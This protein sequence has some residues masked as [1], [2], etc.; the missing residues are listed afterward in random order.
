MP[1][2][3][4]FY[5]NEIQGAT[6]FIDVAGGKDKLVYAVFTTPENAVSGSAICSFKLSDIKHAFDEGQ[7][8][9]QATGNSNWLPV[10]VDET[11]GNRPGQCNQDSTKLPESTLN[12]IKQHSLMDEAVP[13]S[14]IRSSSTEV[15]FDGG[16]P[17]FV[18]TAFNQRLTVVAVDPQIKTPSGESYDVIYAGTTDG[19]VLKIVSVFKEKQ[20][21]DKVVISHKPV[22]LEEIQAFPTHFPIRNVHV[23]QRSASTMDEPRLVVLSD[24]EVKSIPLY[25][26]SKYINCSSCVGLQ[27]PHCAWN[28]ETRRCV[29]HKDFKTTDTKILLQDVYNGQHLG[30]AA[31]GD[32]PRPLQIPQPVIGPRSLREEVLLVEEALAHPTNLIGISVKVEDEDEEEDQ[33]NETPIYGEHKK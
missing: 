4:P 2:D 25:R 22:V 12:F 30:C 8:K 16:N 26:C 6:D 5:F 31:D 15:H 17:T 10:K 32:T 27:D 23:L 1:G 11:N 20:V 14:K 21:E 9:G 7:F 19:K 18:K 13:S 3:I 28:V 24:S 29:N 33:E